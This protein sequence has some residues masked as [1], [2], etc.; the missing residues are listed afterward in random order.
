MSRGAK[1]RSKT[2]ETLIEVTMSNSALQALE[3]LIYVLRGSYD[4]E[5][6]DEK[7][8]PELIELYTKRL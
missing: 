3:E 1:P 6:L 7:T 2:E 5:D 8:L 4:I